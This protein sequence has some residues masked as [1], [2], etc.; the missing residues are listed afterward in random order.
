MVVSDVFLNIVQRV[1]WTI[2]YDIFASFFILE[3]FSSHSLESHGK[4]RP[5]HF[6]KYLCV[7]ACAFHC[8]I[9]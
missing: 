4:E 7:C 9:W 5:A 6:S 8:K 3:S 1:I 2:F